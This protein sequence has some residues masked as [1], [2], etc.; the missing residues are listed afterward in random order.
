MSKSAATTAHSL[1]GL[2]EHSPRRLATLALRGICFSF[3]VLVF[4]AAFL[5]PTFAQ[6]V[7]VAQEG[8]TI[9]G[10]TL[11][12]ILP[13]VSIN[14]AGKMA[15]VADTDTGSLGGTSV[16]AGV[17]RALAIRAAFAPSGTRIYGGFA[18]EGSVQINDADQIIVTERVGFIRLLRIWSA[19]G[20]PAELIA[21]SDLDPD[22]LTI[23]TQSSVNNLGRIAWVGADD[24]VP[25]NV[26]LGNRAGTRLIIENPPRPKPQMA[27]NG[28]IVLRRGALGTGDL[29]IVVV[30]ETFTSGAVIATIGDPEWTDLGIVPGSSDDGGAVAFY[31]VATAAATASLGIKPGPGIFAAFA[32]PLGATGIVRVAGESGNGVIDPGERFLDRNAN[33]TVDPDEDHGPFSGFSTDTRVGIQLVSPDEVLVVYIAHDTSPAQNRGIYATLINIGGAVIEPFDPARFSVEPAYKILAVGDQDLPGLPAGTVADVHVYDP[34]TD[35]GLIGFW[36]SIGG[37]DVAAHTVSLCIEDNLTLRALEVT[38]AIQDWQQSVPLIQDKRTFVRANLELPLFAPSS[39]P[40]KGR[41]YAKR[42]GIVL[43]DPTT[44]KFFLDALDTVELTPI[45][46]AGRNRVNWEKTL[47]FELPADWRKGTIEIRFE[48]LDPE[49]GVPLCVDCNEPGQVPRPPLA[50][51]G[52]AMDCRQVL[53]FEPVNDLVVGF[54]P[55]VWNEIDA[56]TGDE[57]QRRPTGPQIRKLQQRLEALYPLARVRALP[58]TQSAEVRLNPGGLG[59][60]FGDVILNS[61]KAFVQNDPGL[62]SMADQGVKF[63]GVLVGV[64]TVPYLDSGRVIKIVGLADAE[65]RAV[66]FGIMPETPPDFTWGH[67]NHAHEIGHLLGRPHPTHG[68]F[69]LKTD[70]FGCPYSVGSC[71]ERAYKPDAD[72]PNYHDLSS[73]VP[74]TGAPP[75]SSVFSVLSLLPNG[76]TSASQPELHLG[77]P[78][79]IAGLDVYAYDLCA[80]DKIVVDPAKHYEVM[81]YCPNRTLTYAWISDLTYTRLQSK[82]GA[83]PPPPIPPTP[84]PVNYKV[85]RGT[86]DLQFDTVEFQP[87]HTFVAS[88]VPLLPSP[89]LWTFTLVDAGGSVLNVI[90]YDFAVDPVRVAPGFDDPTPTTGSFTITVPNDPAIARVEVARDGALLAAMDASLNAPTV[91]VLFPNG[92]EVVTIDPVILEWTASDADG[93]SLT[94]VVDYSADDGMSWSPVLVDWPGQTADIP[95]ALLAGT[96]QGRIRVTASDGFNTAVDTSDSVFTVPNHL[97]QIFLDLPG[98]GAIFTR[99]QPIQFRA[100]AQDREDGEILGESLEWASSVDGFLGFGSANTIDA[101]LLTE[102]AHE[103][104]VT[105]TDSEGFPTSA[106]VMIRVFREAAPENE[107]PSADAGPDHTAECTSIAGTGVTLDGSGSSDPDADALT[108]AW[109]A[110]GIVFDNSTSVTP[111]GSFPL[112]TTTVTLIVNDGTEDSAPDTVDVTVVD[113]TPPTLL[114]SISPNILWPPKHQMIEVTPSITVSDACDPAPTVV[115]GNVTMDEGDETLAYDPEFDTTLGDGSTTSDI[116]VDQDGRI[117]LRAERSGTGDGRVYTL[118]FEATDASGN[119]TTTSTMVT[120]PHDQSS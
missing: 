14:N 21:R 67:F 22:L 106:S 108:Y 62:A 88:F 101:D 70:S 81:G 28:Q 86:V 68:A 20:A 71:G 66:A 56:A 96:T 35:T 90:S 105:A 102:G 118:T 69:G 110:P 8:D 117:F 100:T 65:K 57:M 98:D 13:D 3:L 107:A 9:D 80:T 76:T 116:Q 72:W 38:Q 27:D 113:A 52:V 41:L 84:V 63:Y 11:Q 33:G 114:V 30:S 58:L 89:G 1:P 104:S 93:D 51:I 49:T 16:Y 91:H 53:I 79:V 64:G 94:Y 44:M 4:S 73:G 31:G 42:N 115:L 46:D 111:T 6:F 77:D 32:L 34:V 18:N 15:F 112:G 24:S 45:D 36:A 19:S 99:D 39:V 60:P 48:A 95:A 87:T 82:L 120:V 17:T 23:L 74:G 119:S 97:P 40:V 83:P 29:R 61:V 5:R 50:P 25:P 7:V 26:F 37:V 75:S 59:V 2:A 43:Q 109:S 85:F 10:D 12:Q 103:I 92:G 55:I 54:I 78:T 47:N